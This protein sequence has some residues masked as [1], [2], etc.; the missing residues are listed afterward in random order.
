MVRHSVGKATMNLPT[1]AISIFVGSWQTAA[2]AKRDP[3]MQLEA[4]DNGSRFNAHVG[5]TIEIA[6][7]ENPTTGYRWTMTPSTAIQLLQDSVFAAD[8]SPGAG[9]RR[10]FRLSVLQR[11]EY[12][13][14]L[15]YERPW[16]GERSAI[17]RFE[18]M[19]V[20]T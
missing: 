12:P 2:E 4:A 11:G 16:E 8:P 1:R 5:D 6:L 3:G 15:R 17:A 10:H 14:L 7:D 18:V 20:V 9:G 19:L 13:L